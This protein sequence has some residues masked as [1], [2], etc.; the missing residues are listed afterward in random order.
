MAG[1]T[2][3]PPEL[4]T[5][6]CKFHLN[7]ADP[8]SK[9]GGRRTPTASRSGPLNSGVGQEIMTKPRPKRIV[10][11]DEDA[12][13]MAPFEIELNMRGYDVTVCATA[14]DCLDLLSSRRRFDLFVVDIMLAVRDESPVYTR[15]QTNDFL[16]TG[17]HLAR[18]I[19]RRRTKTPILLFSN[20]SNKD[21]LDVI[22]SWAKRI[23]NARF[24]PKYIIS[25]GCEFGDMVDRI[26]VGGLPG[27]SKKTAL[28]RLKEAVM[29]EPN[30]YGV[31]IDFKKLKD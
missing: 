31:G 14:E 4:E 23:G 22:Q 19:R 1:V 7:F 21:L 24:V 26:L 6:G 12:I 3:R 28:K 13:Q 8:W 17:L 18:D 11:V 10:V 15:E 25:S 27:T 2:R 30:F 16:L 20:T 9:I 5:Q 29:F